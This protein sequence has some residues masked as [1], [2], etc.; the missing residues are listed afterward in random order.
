MPD[1]S[2]AVSDAAVYAGASAEAW[3]AAS[4]TIPELQ[5]SLQRKARLSGSS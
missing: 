4:A 2:G 3:F 5:L 1:R